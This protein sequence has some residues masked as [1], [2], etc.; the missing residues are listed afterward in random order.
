MHPL[1]VSHFAGDTTVAT[2]DELHATLRLRG[3][4]DDNSFWLAPPA[5]KGY[6]YP[7]LS[8]LVHA[9][10]AV[11][12]YFSEDGDA[13]AQSIGLSDGNEMVEFAQLPGGGADDIGVPQSAV[14]ATDVA[15]RAAEEFALTLARPARIEWF[16]L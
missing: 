11:L 2:L 15:M 7:Q 12:H 6:G 13:G 5:E 4:D 3:S 9:E 1:I 16:Q 8:L 14:L 10:S